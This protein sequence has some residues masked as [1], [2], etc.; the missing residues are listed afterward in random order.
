MQINKTFSKLELINMLDELEVKYNAK[1]NKECNKKEICDYI[2]NN[3][4]NFK[5]K[6]KN[7]KYNIV[8][9]TQYKKYIMS[10]NP[11][12][13]TSI[14]NKNLI[15]LNAKRIINYCMQDYSIEN[16][17]FNNIDEIEE[18]IDDI[19]EYTNIASVRR[20][21]K[22]YNNNPNLKNKIDYN[23][24]DEI[25]YTLKEKEQ[26]KY[27]CRIRTG[28]FRYDMLNCKMEVIRED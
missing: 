24:I 14:K 18:I 9:I 7:N 3:Y 21:L 6:N 17:T 28:I 11:I 22:L 10:P 23:I 20:A 25:K 19:K 2:V 13:N 1:I 16:S 15:M 27:F 12:K 26:P 5:I 4:R 8:N